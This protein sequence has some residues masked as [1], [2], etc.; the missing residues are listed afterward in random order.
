[1]VTWSGINTDKYKPLKAFSLEFSKMMQ[2]I[3]TRSLPPAELR[4]IAQNYSTDFL[5]LKQ[6]RKQVEKRINGII[7]FADYRYHAQVCHKLIAAR[8]TW[9]TKAMGVAYENCWKEGVFDQLNWEFLNAIFAVSTGG[10]SDKVCCR[11]MNDIF[12]TY[13]VDVDWVIQ[14]HESGILSILLLPQVAVKINLL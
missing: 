5:L 9:Q 4:P 12:S 14:Q 8:D 10:V 3:H 11:T 1:M 6:Y 7:A 2:A 13:P